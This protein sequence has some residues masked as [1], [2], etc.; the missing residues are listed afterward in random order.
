MDKN[1]MKQFDA[2]L[3]SQLGRL[4]MLLNEKHQKYGNTPINKTGL[5]GIITKLDIKIERLRTLEA[6]VMTIEDNP[7]MEDEWRED[8]QEQLIDIAGYGVLG[9]MWLKGE[10]R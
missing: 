2:K 5:M 7:D 10:L 8:V 6:S 9:L 4:Q 3:Q 1:Y